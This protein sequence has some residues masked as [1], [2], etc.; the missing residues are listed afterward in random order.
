M[1]VCARACMTPS[2]LLSSTSLSACTMTG[3]TAIL[4]ACYL[5]FESHEV[6]YRATRT[7]RILI[8]GHVAVTCHYVKHH[9]VDE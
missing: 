6:T 2:S 9:E 8:A 1:G 5:A 7:P 3:G 4:C